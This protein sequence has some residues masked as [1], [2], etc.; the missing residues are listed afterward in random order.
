MKF[1]CLAYEEQAVLDALTP[2]ECGTR[3]TVVKRSSYI[4]G[5]RVARIP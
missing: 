5:L 3:A 4:D 1:L 2:P